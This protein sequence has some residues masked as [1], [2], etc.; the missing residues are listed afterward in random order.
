MPGNAAAADD[1]LFDQATREVFRTRHSLQI[2]LIS[3]SHKIK[4]ETGWT[5][6]AIST[7][8]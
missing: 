2:T 5:F 1:P 6:A 7:Q 8:V 3:E 4:P